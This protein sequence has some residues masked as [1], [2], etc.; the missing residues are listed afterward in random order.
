[1]EKCLE[2]NLE[3][4]DDSSLHKHLK[5]HKI[6]VCDYYFKH[7]PKKDL[8]TGEWI[9]FKSKE[10]YLS[11]DFNNKTNFKKWL[12]N[13]DENKQREYCKNFLIKRKQEKEIIYTPCQVELTS[14]LSPGINFLNA[15]FG[16]Y[17]KQCESLGF[18]NKHQYPSLLIKNPQKTSKNSEK[19][20]IDTREQKGLN[21]NFSS[22]IKTLKFG[23]YAFSKEGTKIYFERKSISDLIGTLS[24]GYERFER[25][26]ERA[27]AANSKLIIIVEEKLSNA[28]NFEYLPH[29]YKKD[30]RVNSSYIFHKVR[31]LIQKYPHI[32]FLFCDGRKE[33]VRVIEKIFSTDIDYMSFDLQLAYILKLL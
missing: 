7:F 10:Q 21:F 23:D 12:L 2:C 16:D 19:I 18:I 22:E 5:A 17:Y 13:Q 8:Y 3:F 1:M 11:T 25:E 4:S 29:V 9:N 20:Y 33:C 28:L 31:Q 26:I 6:K 27:D 24:G 30:T 15:L 14:L 32:Q